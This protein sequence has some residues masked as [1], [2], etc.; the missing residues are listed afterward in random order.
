MP[1]TENMNGD[2]VTGFYALALFGTA[3]AILPLET[4]RLAAEEDAAMHA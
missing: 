1:I 2:I 4:A 3:S